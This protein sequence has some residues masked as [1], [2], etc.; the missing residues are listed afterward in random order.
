[1]NK[2]EMRELKKAL[3]EINNALNAISMQSELAMMY[4]TQG[5]TDRVQSAIAIVM[6]SCRSCS[7]ISHDLQARLFPGDS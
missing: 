2:S 4:A 1:M 3:H 7:T 6:K 5:D